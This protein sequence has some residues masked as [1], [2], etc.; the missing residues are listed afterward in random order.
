[1]EQVF[2]VNLRMS[3]LAIFTGLLTIRA[4]GLL[5]AGMHTSETHSTT[6]TNNR[7]LTGF[8]Y[9]SGNT[10]G[11][12]LSQITSLPETY[13]IHRADTHACVATGTLVRNH[14]RT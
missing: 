13:I 12:I 2:E 6:V 14:F 11:A 9:R 10:I 3:V 8:V 1:M 7:D 4:D 5:R